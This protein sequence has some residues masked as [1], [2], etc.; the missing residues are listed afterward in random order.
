MFYRQLLLK[1]IP[2]EKKTNTLTVFFALSGSECV[3]AAC[4]MMMK[5]T[6]EVRDRKREKS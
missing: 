1:K 3:K 6:P 5:S 4:K 2:K